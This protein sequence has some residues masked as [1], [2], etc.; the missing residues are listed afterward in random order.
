MWRRNVRVRYKT[1]FLTRIS[2][3]VNIMEVYVC[4]VLMGVKLC[5]L[6]IKGTVEHCVLW[7]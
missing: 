1:Q 6:L 4:S 2:L 5:S 3:Y 7:C